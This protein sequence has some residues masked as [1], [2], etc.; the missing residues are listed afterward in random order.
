[1][2]HRF[3]ICVSGAS[4]GLELRKF[5]ENRATGRRRDPSKPLSV[6]G[7]PMPPEVQKQSAPW[8]RQIQTSSIIHA[9]FTIYYKIKFPLL[10][11]D[12]QFQGAHFE[13]FLA[14]VL[15]ST[16]WIA[17]YSLNFDLKSFCWEKGPGCKFSY[18]QIIFFIYK[19][20]DIFQRL[21]KINSK[22]PSIS[23][24]PVTSSLWYM[25]LH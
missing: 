25:L 21:Q 10:F 24:F 17:V 15:L 14:L 18:E 20:Y 8:N 1:M 19:S 22:Q 9:F 2:G 12:F 13:R 4:F 6:W 3:I 5:W 23:R 16:Q 7:R 11:P